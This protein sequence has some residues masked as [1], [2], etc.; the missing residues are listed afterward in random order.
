MPSGRPARSTW[1]DELVGAPPDDGFGGSFR[2]AV[3]SL[4]RNALHLLALTVLLLIVWAA[5]SIGTVTAT[6]AVVANGVG[7]GALAVAI[8]SFVIQ[9]LVFAWVLQGFAQAWSM[10]VRGSPIRFDE[11]LLPRNFLSILGT[12]VLV[13]PLQVLFGIALGFTYSAIFFTVGD[14]FGPAE[15]VGQMLRET[16]SSSRRFLHTL[17]IGVASTLSL[18]T[19]GF[20]TFAL[21]NA[22]ILGVATSGTNQFTINQQTG[23]LET[24]NRA[25][26]TA[27]T[28]VG[29]VA[30]ALFVLVGLTVV[31]NLVGLWAAAHSRDLTGRPLGRRVTRVPVPGPVPAG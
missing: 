23:A 22:A 21:L 13:S 12:T 28:I 25:D 17:F 4:W 11:V 27:T 5:T 19:M 9:W 3:H 7:I 6:T 1:R 26:F 18:V 30:I 10:L 29:T 14:G 2:W 31:I 15:A 16:F 20:V 24:V 8:G